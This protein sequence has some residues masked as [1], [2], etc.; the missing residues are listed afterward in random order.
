VRIL[1]ENGGPLPAGE[2]GEIY[3]RRAGGPESTFLYIG[4]D[5][6]CRGE[7]ASFGDMGWLDAEG[8]LY[9]ADR[10]TDMIVSGGVNIFPAEVEAQIDT[11]PGVADSIVAAAPHADLGAVPHAF[12]L[13]QPNAP[14]WSEASLLEALRERLAPHKMPRGVT[15]VNESLR[16]D[17]GKIRRAAWRDRLQ[18]S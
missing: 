6:R 5:V 12:V 18:S 11:L 15:F 13:L 9:I 1:D 2:V 3:F 17:S 4:A 16:D 14:H 10:R 7:W 8:Y